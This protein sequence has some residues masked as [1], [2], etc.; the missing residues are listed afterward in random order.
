[1]PPTAIGNHDF[2]TGFVVFCVD[3]LAANGRI[4]G[5]GVMPANL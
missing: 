1:M 5:A 4:A 2:I 3:N